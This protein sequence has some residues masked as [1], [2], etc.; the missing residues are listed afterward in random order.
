VVV[1]LLA[2]V[3]DG[4]RGRGGGGHGGWLFN[5]LLRAAVGGEW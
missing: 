3:H 4:G 5:A 2:A 1:D